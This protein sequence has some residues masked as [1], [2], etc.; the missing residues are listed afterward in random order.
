MKYLKYILTF[1]IVSI[2]VNAQNSKSDEIDIKFTAF[3]MGTVI[4]D[5]FFDSNGESKPLLVTD[6]NRTQKF[7]Y[8]GP[9]KLVTYT[10]KILDDGTVVKRKFASANV[11]IHYKHLFLIFVPAKGKG[12]NIKYKVLA[13][14]DSPELYPP[15]SYRLFNGTPSLIA[16][17]FGGKGDEAFKLPAGSITV[18]PQAA[19]EENQKT[20]QLGIYNNENWSLLYQSI[21]S[22]RKGRK[23][24][25]FITARDTRPDMISV[26]KI[27]EN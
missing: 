9:P 26:R 8:K 14:N 18:V 15:S 2:S 7:H 16:G 20:I 25:I 22:Y 27:Y 19:I 21:W 5:V 10:K 17:K 12:D 3:S 4:R 1:L 11:P 6:G 13:L 23:A 24:L